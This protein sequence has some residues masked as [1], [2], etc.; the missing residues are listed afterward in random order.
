MW[1]HVWELLRRSSQL[2]KSA[3]TAHRKGFSSS[4]SPKGAKSIA[5]KNRSLGLGLAAVVIGAIGASY[6]AVPLYRLFCQVSG[7]GGTTKGHKGVAS[8]A[9]RQVALV[10]DRPITVYFN[11]DTRCCFFFFFSFLFH[12]FFSLLQNLR[13]KI[14][15]HFLSKHLKLFLPLT[16]AQPRL[17]MDFQTTAAPSNCNSWRSS[18]RFL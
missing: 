11:A 8:L 9:E 17:A 14:F 13:C 5:E 12:F 15:F 18:T 2:R 3:A 4:S 6:A 1:R 7:Y 10:P 16:F